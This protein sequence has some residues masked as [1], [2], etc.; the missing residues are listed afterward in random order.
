MSNKSKKIRNARIIATDIFMFI[1][2]VAIVFL[3]MLIAMGFKFNDE[4]NLEQSGLLQLSSRPSSAKVSIDGKEL[5]MPTEISKLLSIGDHDVKVTKAGY[6]TWNATVKID[7]GLLTNISWVRLFPLNPEYT[8]VDTF[9]KEPAFVSVS[10]SRKYML[11][12]EAGSDHFDYLSLQEEK[13]KSTAIN[14]SDII[15]LSAD[16][17]EEQPTAITPNE[18]NVVNWSNNDSKILLTHTRSGNT[19]WV[20]VNASKPKEN[21]NLTT[22][23]DKKFTQ[24]LFE[25]ESATKAWALADGE[26]YQLDLSNK[27]ISK[28]IAKNVKKIDNDGDVIA[29]I[30]TSNEEVIDAQS[31]EEA[32]LSEAKTNKIFIYKDGE[33]SSTPIVDLGSEEA[34]S[35]LEMGTY[36]SHNWLAYNKGNK[37]FIRNGVYPSYNKNSLEDF[38]VKTEE[39]LE[40][41]PATTDKDYES[42]I[43]ILANENK[44]TSYDLETKEFYSYQTDAIVS[45]INWLDDYML[46]QQKDGK[47]IV[48]DFDGNN[49]REIIQ[50]LYGN[51][52]VMLSRNNKYLYYF[53]SEEI[54]DTAKA[55]TEENTEIAPTKKTI[56]H[57]TRMDLQ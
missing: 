29:Y 26:L 48:W 39:E 23:F 52:P 42:R 9:N 57:L 30:A 16:E 15:S 49:H 40:F 19:N 20:L 31:S 5:L 17:D 25:N 47:L 53:S 45:K 14:F 22:T 24:V 41:T 2:V 21:L 54:T 10:D 51:Y 8:D 6:D 37:L 18:F 55:G 32:E 11:I 46:W 34:S 35:M 27:S 12:S 13:I 3:M 7:S 33:E 50:K 28:A 1:A 44:I 38:P 43:I 36:W 56:Y 4:G